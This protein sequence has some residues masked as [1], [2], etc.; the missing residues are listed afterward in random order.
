MI[1]KIK[2]DAS[3]CFCVEHLDDVL[4]DIAIPDTEQAGGDARVHVEFRWAT[5]ARTP[6]QTMR[7][8]ARDHVTRAVGHL[9]DGHASAVLDA[10]ALAA[11]DELRPQMAATGLSYVHKN[12]ILKNLLAKTTK[13]TFAHIQ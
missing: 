3:V 12:P 11:L 6:H 1:L 13:K 9:L 10:L 8:R 2:H 4:V 7:V 5:S